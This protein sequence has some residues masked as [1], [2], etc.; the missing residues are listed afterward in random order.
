MTTHSVSGLATLFTVEGAALGAARNYSFSGS[1][2]MI[3]ATSD[4]SSRWGEYLVGRRDWNIDIDMLYIYDNP[5]QIYL[6]EHWTGADPASL[7]V[8]WTMPDG[9]TYTG[10]ALLTSYSLTSP[11]EDVITASVSLQGTDGITTSTS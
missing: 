5:A 11:Y 8:I 4:D 7:T 10:T 3:D 9:R 2:A 1:Q 6:E